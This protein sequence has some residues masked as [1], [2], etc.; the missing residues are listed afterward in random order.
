M[1]SK[2]RNL[3]IIS[4][5]LLF[6]ITLSFF[7]KCNNIKKAD[8]FIDSN[9]IVNAYINNEEKATIDYN[10]KLIEVSGTIKK[11]TLLDKKNTI[12]LN[13]NNKDSGIICELNDNQ[14]ELLKTLKKN[15]K[16]R[17]KGICKGFLKDV[18]FLNCYIVETKTNE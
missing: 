15:Q 1:I 8:L 6:F 5:V 4:I 18:I 7:Y 14:I 9:T 13:S 3:C 11:I 10:D 17:I 12:V 16:T 2:K